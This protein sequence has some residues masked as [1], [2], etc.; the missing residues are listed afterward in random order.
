MIRSSHYSEASQVFSGLDGAVLV[1]P[2]SSKEA[3][4]HHVVGKQ[5]KEDCQDKDKQELS[6]PQTQ[7]TFVLQAP[8]YPNQLSSEASAPAW[9]LAMRQ[10]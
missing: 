6:N 5:K 8:L 9:V 1:A 3:V 10:L 7:W 4:T 2:A